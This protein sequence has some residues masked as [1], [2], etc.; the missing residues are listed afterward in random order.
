MTLA[1]VDRFLPLAHEDPAPGTK[2]QHYFDWL[3]FWFYEDRGLP[4]THCIDRWLPGWARDRYWKH[5]R[6]PP[7]T[8]QVKSAE[9]TRRH[10][11]AL[12]LRGAGLTYTAIGARMHLSAQR[13]GQVLAQAQS[14]VNQFAPPAAPDAPVVYVRATDTP[15]ELYFPLSGKTYRLVDLRDE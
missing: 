10:R 9:L 7:Y 6:Q 8:V 15:G 14:H 5:E 11:K 12:Q 3:R 13:V 1:M 4:Q 2:I